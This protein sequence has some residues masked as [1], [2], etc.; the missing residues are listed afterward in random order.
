MLV[1]IPCQ[2][3]DEAL[4]K[5]VEKKSLNTFEFSNLALP[6]LPE[7]AIEWLAPGTALFDA[8]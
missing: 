2:N 3:I 4:T 1:I 5:S 6:S 8:Q 7:R